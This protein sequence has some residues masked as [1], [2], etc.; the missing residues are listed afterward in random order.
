MS[1]TFN[2][3]PYSLII[4]CYSPNNASNERDIIVFLK[5]LSSLVQHILKHNVPFIGGDRNA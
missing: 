3:N 2:G 5:K 4:S 1:A